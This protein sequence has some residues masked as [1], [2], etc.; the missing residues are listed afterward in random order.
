[1]VPKPKKP[2]SDNKNRWQ[3]SLL[4]IVVMVLVIGSFALAVVDEGFRPAFADLAKVTMAA[5]LG[6]MT[7]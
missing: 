2:N 6:S 5:Y 3:D 4:G 1:M 7:K